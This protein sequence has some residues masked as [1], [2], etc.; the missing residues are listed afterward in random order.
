MELTPHEKK[1]LSLVQSNPDIV[2]NSKTR[3]KVAK[4]NGLSEKTLRNRI[5]DLRKYGLLDE[6]LKNDIEKG[7]AISL[8]KDDEI[9]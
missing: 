4:K 8:N 9:D 7:P 2:T 3:A 6:S 1:I 5:G